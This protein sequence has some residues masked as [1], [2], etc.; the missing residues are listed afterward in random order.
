VQ[1]NG[2]NEPRHEGETVLGYQRSTIRFPLG[3]HPND[4]LF[5]CVKLELHIT[6]YYVS[7]HNGLLHFFVLSFRIQER[8]GCRN[9]ALDDYEVS[10]FCLCVSAGD[11][12]RIGSIA[13]YYECLVIYAAQ[14]FCV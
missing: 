13:R 4:S 5:R 8:I 7:V 11:I 6:E 14:L 12:L 10:S 3:F 9:A 1:N 2:E